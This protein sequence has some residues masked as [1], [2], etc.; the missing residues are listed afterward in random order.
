MAGHVPYVEVK[1]DGS[2]WTDIT[3]YVE[4]IEVFRGRANDLEQMQAGTARLILDNDDGRFTPENGS[5]A[6]DPN[7]EPG[8]AV[9]IRMAAG[10]TADFDDA[11]VDYEESEVTYDGASIVHLFTGVAVRWEPSWSLDGDATVL[12]ECV[13]GF[14]Q[15][16]N[17]VL[18]A[19]YTDEV[20]DALPAGG[21]W[22]LSQTAGVFTDELND[23]HMLATGEGGTLERGTAAQVAIGEGSV[24]FTPDG[25]VGHGLISR[26]VPPSTWTGN[27]ND[28]TISLWVA[29]PDDDGD[30]VTLLNIVDDSDPT[31]FPWDFSRSN[32]D[33]LEFSIEGSGGSEILSSD[34]LSWVEGRTYHVGM[35]WDQSTKTATFYRDGV[36]VGSDTATGVPDAPSRFHLRMLSSS[37]PTTVRMSEVV[38]WPFDRS[39][40]MSDL[41]D[42]GEGWPSDL[43]GTRIGRILDLAGWDAA[44]RSLDTGTTSL[45]ALSEGTALSACQDAAGADGGVFYI[46][47]SGDATFQGRRGRWEDDN[48]V[49][50]T[51]DDDGT[52]T[53]Y[54]QI[55]W[56][57]DTTLL[58]NRVKINSN[59]QGVSDASADA[60][61]GSISQYGV[62]VLSISTISNDTDDNYW[63]AQWEVWRRQ[64]PKLRLEMI[65][66]EVG[67][68]SEQDAAV[69][70]ELQDMVHAYRRPGAGQ[71]DL[72]VDLRIASIRHSVSNSGR[73]W[74]VEFGLTEAETDQPAI[75]GV[76]LYN[77]S[78]YGY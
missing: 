51:F 22:K 64:L 50:V 27:A 39:A 4:G 18:R 40:L 74:D 49:V 77:G 28:L 54:Q 71:S 55:G 7:V 58:H 60:P 12:L 76:S 68:V 41:A 25:T 37:Q 35:H 67:E 62:R 13:D 72:S 70:L 15:L 34:T 52:D 59:T 43:P 78:R 75:Y 46:S 42:A 5:G 32:L 10:S 29:F 24:T 48:T 23:L 14:E 47:R 69:T 6:Y 31:D 30:S 26:D 8:V 9:R 45:A 17:H 53:P 61:G 16:R 36:E 11:S 21:Y 19:P 66:G 65:G 38:L 3:E 20:W 57:Y 73:K 2:T 63:R 56:R 1:F 44:D 33:R